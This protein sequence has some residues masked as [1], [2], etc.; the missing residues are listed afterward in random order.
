MP[1]AS[2]RSLL[3]AELAAL[4]PRALRQRAEA[5]PGITEEQLDAVEETDDPIV[6]LLELVVQ[7]ELS[8]VEASK[9]DARRAELEEEV[10]ALKPRALRRRAATAPG[11]TEDQLDGAEEAADPKLALVEIVVN[12][13]LQAE[14]AREARA[15]LEAELWSLKPRA[16]QKRAESAP[17]VS[18][19]E[20]DGALEAADTKRALIELVVGA[21]LSCDPGTVPVPTLAN[22]VDLLQ[23]RPQA[24]VSR[25][26][27]EMMAPES[28]AR[29]DY[30]A[31]VP[32]PELGYGHGTRTSWPAAPADGVRT[33]DPLVAHTARI[34][35]G[36]ED[37]QR[38]PPEIDFC[39]SYAS[40]DFNVPTHVLDAKEQLK[41]RGYQVF[42][43]KDVD[44]LSPQD[45]RV[46]WM[47]ACDRSVLAVNFLSVAYMKSQA[48]ASEWNHPK[49]KELN[50][51]FGGSKQRKAILAVTTA[52]MADTGA[53][54]ITMY[55][56]DGGQATSVY[57]PNSG[58]D[59]CD[60]TAVLV[61]AYLKAKRALPAN[62]PANST[63]PLP[64][65]PLAVTPIHQNAIPAPVP[66]PELQQGPEPEPI[67]LVRTNSVLATAKVEDLLMEI[68][69][70]Q[71]AAVFSQQGYSFVSD[72]LD[73][74]ASKQQ[75]CL[76]LRKCARM[77]AACRSDLSRVPVP[78]AR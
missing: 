72:L 49:S 54:A 52:E 35:P 36:G 51:I 13:E 58:R 78:A 24:T 47:R 1:P 53:A 5:A 75:T 55:L 61:D 21:G 27:A 66:P 10:S 20:L 40:E 4:R 70:E 67:D 34:P 15:E 23:S 48:C 76:S 30:P 8:S 71:Y 12:L 69:L 19:E 50:V 62:K 33:D 73:A 77:Q 26:A 2:R 7:A 57:A 46:Q 64:S 11:V 56:N 14:H 6:A 44:A 39:F 45:W 42:Y 63:E 68:D 31:S 41:R 17:G 32:E 38:H 59:P 74:D 65:I 29:T 3:R 16:L 22:P 28:G 43:G 25:T 60:L 9:E 18:E 37:T